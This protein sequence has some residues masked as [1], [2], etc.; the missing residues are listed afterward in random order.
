MSRQLDTAVDAAFASFQAGDL[1]GAAAACAEVLRKA[2]RNARALRL[3]GAVR[4]QGGDAQSASALLDKAARLSPA[5][6]RVHEDLAVAQLALGEYGAAERTLR[7]ALKLAARPRAS[8]H[9]RLAYALNGLERHDESEDALRAALGLEPHMVALM[10]DLANA[11]AR[12][13][14]WSEARTW[15]EQAAAAEPERPE[16][17]FNLAVVLEREGRHEDAAQAYAEVITRFPT[18]HDAYINLGIVHEYLGRT[19][20]ALRCYETALRIDPASAHAYANLG[21][22]L[23]AAGRLD[24]AQAACLQAL[25]I[26]PAF[27]DAMVNLAGV[28]TDQGRAEE[29]LAE[30]ERALEI[31]PEAADAQ[32]SYAALNLALGR[33]E[34]GWR[35]YAWRPTRLRARATQIELDDRL[36]AKLERSHILVLGEQGL[37]DE[38]FFLRYAAALQARGAHVHVECDPRLAT[39]LDRSGAFESVTMPGQSRPLADHTYVAGD[40]PLLFLEA[41]HSDIPP[42]LALSALESRVTSVRETLHRLGPPPYMGLTWAAGTP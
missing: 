24:E 11:L 35:S 10:M 30:Y 19:D 21:K 26:A 34:Q 28:L 27:S 7:R 5:D 2:P 13:G 38:L 16:A 40:L 12:R 41:G 23:R 22:A 29:A 6:D 42:P 9:A 3:L 17:V 14:A 1:G 4:L 18:Y 20:E 8:L 25:R 15:F 36:P 31:D 39:L 37:G 32:F 33:Y